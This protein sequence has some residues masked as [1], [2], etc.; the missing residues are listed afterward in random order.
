MSFILDALKK[1]E[2]ERQRQSGPAFA[3]V[4]V[5]QPRARQPW[6][7]FAIAALLFVNL[8]V[9][10]IVLLQREPEPTAPAVQTSPTAAPTPPPSATRQTVPT[11]SAPGG[12]MSPS[13]VVARAP[14]AAAPPQP[15]PSHVDRPAAP[16]HDPGMT[17]TTSGSA[18]AEA[19]GIA[20]PYAEDPTLEY[21]EFEAAASQVPAGRSIVQPLAQ[22]GAPAERAEALPTVNDLNLSGGASLPELHLD[23]HVYA[24][25]P[26]ERFVFVNM[27]K[28][29]EGQK[30]QEGPLVER[31]TPEGVVLN[32]QGLRFLLPSQ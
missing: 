15:D 3:E 32:Q 1:S 9:L 29:L 16:A 12:A 6:W 13:S 11:P 14:T 5:A 17:R 23:I 28:Y 24:P 30:L 20:D 19:A 8:F 18:L 26:A 2:N 10:V 4:P 7:V 21:G 25:I 31:I 27:R 22:N